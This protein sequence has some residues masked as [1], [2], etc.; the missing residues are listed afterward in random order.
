MKVVR[1]RRWDPAMRRELL[2]LVADEQAAL[3]P[4]VRQAMERLRAG[5]AP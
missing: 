3:H 5:K 2:A 1:T 4:L